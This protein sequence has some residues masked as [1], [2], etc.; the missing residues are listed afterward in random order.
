MSHRKS[1]M[2]RLTG[3][4]KKTERNKPI[5]SEFKN[6]AK[7]VESLIQAG[8]KEEAKKMLNEFMSRASR[9]ASKGIIPKG[10]ADRKISRL[11]SKIHKISVS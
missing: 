3:N 6:Y 7:K 11:A 8:K 4:V 9:A 10:R 5:H 2:K 1:A